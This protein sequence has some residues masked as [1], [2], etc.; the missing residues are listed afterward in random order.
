VSDHDGTVTHWI[1]TLTDVQALKER[2]AGL[3]DAVRGRDEYLAALGHE[4]RTPLQALK[5]V[6]YVLRMPELPAADAEKM[7]RSAE[8]QVIELTRFCDEVLD[9]NKVR[10]DKMSVVVEPTTLE[11]V[12]DAAV[13]AASPKIQRHGHS[14]DIE[15]EN[16]D[17]AITVDRVRVTQ[18]LV[19]LLDN[20]A[21]YT[22][23]RGRLVLRA[24]VRDANVEFIVGDSGQG[25][26]ADVLPHIFDLFSR[27]TPGAATGFGIG[28]ALVQ[29]V[30]TL[31]GGVIEAHSDG[32]GQGSRFT[33]RLPAVPSPG[34]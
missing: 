12:I 26:D 23:R 25:I 3:V 19:N 13:S 6:L 10:W 5:Q 17:A 34:V 9:V 7:H 30:A 29:R 27:G 11:S 2:E 24:A 28:L 22:D 14:L 1:G 33:L 15:I 31:H 18:A 32:P 4:L 21:K 20:A 8:N 16:P